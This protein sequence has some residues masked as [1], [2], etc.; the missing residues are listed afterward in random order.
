LLVDA[1]AV[2]LDLDPREHALLL[3]A[4]AALG[5]DATALKERIQQRL[6]LPSEP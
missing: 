6:K 1:A 5:I 4:A 2:D 3:A